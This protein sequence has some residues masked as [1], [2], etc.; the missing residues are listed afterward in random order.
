[1]VGGREG[2]RKGEKQ[3]ERWR[4]EREETARD[5]TRARTV[6]IRRDTAWTRFT[7]YRRDRCQFQSTLCRRQHVKN[8]IYLPHPYI[9]AIPHVDAK[10]Y[11]A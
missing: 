4:G 7:R 9:H 10:L 2:G 5:L 6:S 11:C 8:E 3:D 1:M